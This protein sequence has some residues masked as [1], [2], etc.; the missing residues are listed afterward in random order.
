M[1]T[2]SLLAI[3]L[4]IPAA[5]PAPSTSLMR[6]AETHALRAVAAPPRQ[7]APAAK[8]KDHK[9]DGALAG[10]LAGAGAGA[11]TGMLIYGQGS[12][13]WPEMRV[14][15][16]GCSFWGALIGGTT[17]LIIDSLRR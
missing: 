6:Q 15:V 3:A 17:G 4:S 2:A 12:G 8:S 10:A 7:D 5:A 11:L 13:E 1:L 9:W 14:I 16:A